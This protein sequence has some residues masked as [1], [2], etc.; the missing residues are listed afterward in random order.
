MDK[1][2]KTFF[3][4][5]IGTADFYFEKLEQASEFFRQVVNAPIRNIDALG[6]GE[7]RYAFDSGGKIRLSMKQETLD[8]Y[9]SKEA[10]EFAKHKDGEKE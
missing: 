3:V 6:Y 5:E 2:T 7:G 10:A 9:P 8:F 4:V 1:Q